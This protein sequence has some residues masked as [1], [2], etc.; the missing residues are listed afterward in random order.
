MIAEPPF[1]TGGVNATDA[2]A[3]PPV[4]VPIAG[5]PGTPTAVPEFEAADEADVP[6]ALVAVTVK[7]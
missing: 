4:A 7:V 3:L 5:A 6:T 1:D 2:C